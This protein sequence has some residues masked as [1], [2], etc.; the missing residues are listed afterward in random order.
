MQYAAKMVKPREN[1]GEQSEEEKKQEA[2]KDDEFNLP[3]IVT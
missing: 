1:E 2:I 3:Q